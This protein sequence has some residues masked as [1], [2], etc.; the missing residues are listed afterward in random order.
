MFCEVKTMDK[1]RSW[2]KQIEETLRKHYQEQEG[3]KNLEV[4]DKYMDG[5][6]K[7]H[8]LIHSWLDHE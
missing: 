2:I 5:V 6:K 1:H 4:N 3:V 7:V 8:L